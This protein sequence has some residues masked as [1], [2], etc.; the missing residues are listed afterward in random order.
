MQVIRKTCQ[1]PPHP[2]HLK[3]IGLLN[4]LFGDGAGLS[5]SALGTFF[6]LG[7]AFFFGTGAPASLSLLFATAAFTFDG[8]ARLVSDVCE[9]DGASRLT[10]PFAPT[11]R[12]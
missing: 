11:L 3:P 9:P 7:F 5:P 12:A 6:F 4:G 10:P 1:R 2:A 8:L